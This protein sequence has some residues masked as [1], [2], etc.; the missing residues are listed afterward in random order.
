MFSLLWL[1]SARYLLHHPWQLALSLLGIAL[2]VAVVVAV[3]LAHES[4][5]LSFKLSS[6]RLSGVPPIKLQAIA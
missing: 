6:E 3:D 4:A 1:S 2:G 5:R